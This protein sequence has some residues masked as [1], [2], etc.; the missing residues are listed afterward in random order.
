MGIFSRTKAERQLFR[1][2]GHPMY[3]PS[4][5]A[6]DVEA[7]IRQ[8]AKAGTVGPDGTPL[9]AVAIFGNVE[10]AEVLL[11]HGADV[12][13]LSFLSD[14]PLH[15]AAMN[16]HLRLMQVLIDHGAD[17]NSR[18]RKSG[19]TPLHRTVGGRRL[20]AAELLLQAGANPSIQDRSGNTPIRT[21]EDL[22]RIFAGRPPIGNETQADL[23]AMVD[24]IKAFQHMLA[25]YGAR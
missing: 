14:T 16:G 19:E 5:K 10:V 3:A 23:D 20:R 11:R 22:L 12:N 8:G 6:S 15:I 7:L 2:L 21:A 25:R 13:G 18:D 9:H 24:E 1:L 4:L 17:V